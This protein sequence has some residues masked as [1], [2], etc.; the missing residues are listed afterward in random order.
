MRKAPLVRLFFT[1]GVV[2]ILATSSLSS[3]AQPGFSNQADLVIS[4]VSISPEKPIPG[5]DAIITVVVTN[6][7]NEDV[8]QNFDVEFQIAFG[9][10]ELADIGLGILVGIRIDKAL[11]NRRIRPG[12]SFDVKFT[13]RV[14]QLPQFKFIFKVDS[15]FNTIQESDETNNRFEHIL[16]IGEDVLSQWWLDAINVRE[17]WETTRGSEDIIVAVIDTGVDHTHPEFAGNLWVNPADGSH[18]F[19]FIE[20]HNG[21]QR[22]TQIDFH[23][24]S[25]AGLIGAQDDGLGVTGVAPDV[26]IM[27]L[28]V[29]PTDGGASFGDIASAINFAIA[30][31]ADII[32][33]SLGTSFCSASEF[34][35]EDRTNVQRAINFLN[36]WVQAAINNGIVVV[37]SAGNNARCVTVPANLDNVIAVSATNIANDPSPFTSFGP[38]VVV[39]AP[40]GSLRF[41]DFIDALKLDFQLLIPT[42]E[43]L[44]VTPYVNG[45]YGWFTGTSASA[46][47]VSGVIA[48]MLSVNP[49]MTTFQIRDVLARTAL[50]LGDPGFDEFYGYG[51]IDAAAAVKCAA[52]GGR[53]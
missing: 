1:I 3:Q 36:S 12:E 40:G 32:N 24:T 49:N 8:Q 39:G 16:D 13:W 14:L 46:P 11:V 20:G 28:R 38:E 35:P 18:G 33:L 30:N 31:G 2:L 17:A 29:F 50:D 9:P 34:A 51:L 19:D 43:T 48:L 26:Q 27:D 44:L 15:P 4:G 37:S 7:G 25:V 22:T 5:Q 52:N 23:G 6:E 10:Q 21:L 45:N 42:L 47:I 41:E 53:C